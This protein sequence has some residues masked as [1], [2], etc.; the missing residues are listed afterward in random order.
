MATRVMTQTVK[1]DA[2]SRMFGEILFG[3][4]L[5]PANID[6]GKLYAMWMRRG[7]VDACGGECTETCDWLLDGR[8]SACVLLLT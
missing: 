7:R 2:I 4:R 5:G 3:G 8:L 6:L 1:R